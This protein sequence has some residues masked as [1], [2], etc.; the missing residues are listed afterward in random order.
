MASPWSLDG[1]GAERTEGDGRLWRGECTPWA[2]PQLWQLPLCSVSGV[3]MGY[4]EEWEAAYAR[5]NAALRRARTPPVSAVISL[6]LT[7]M[8]LSKWSSWGK[9][10][11]ILIRT[12]S[13]MYVTVPVAPLRNNPSG[14]VASVLFSRTRCPR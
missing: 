6:Y 14:R 5:R 8:A 2:G 4:F 11:S 1:D 13:S 9:C 3:K 12:I 7:H 10:W